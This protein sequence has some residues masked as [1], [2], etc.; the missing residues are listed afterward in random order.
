V[1]AHHEAPLQGRIALVTGASSGIG[2]ACALALAR[3]GAT[4]ALVARRR[5][6]L[7][8]LVLT[9]ASIG[10]D[11]LVLEA[12][13]AESGA[14]TRV[15]GEAERAFGQLDILVNNAGVMYLE[16]IEAASEEHLRRMLEVNLLALM[17]GCQA[18]LP[19][20]RARRDG[21]IVN[22][23]SVA[24]RVANPS[25]A[26]YAASKFGV[27]AFSESL[28]REVVRDRVRVTVIEPGLVDTELRSHLTHAATIETI[29]AFAASVRPLRSEDIANA[30][31]YAVTQ[32]PHV[33]VNEILIR[34]TDQER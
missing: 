12:D 16:P 19:G 20:M 17:L 34:P 26:G 9:L 5:D 24:G 32:P 31:L 22:I 13:L 8:Q 33:N 1:S 29:E 18:A 10:A 2:E 30:V 4:V 7:E 6:R 27:V 15:V 11:S 28:R 21:H 25:S 23:A 3:A 14:A